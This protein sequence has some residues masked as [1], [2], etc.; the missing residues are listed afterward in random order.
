M[1]S[2]I[3]VEGET[4]DER[5]R[6]QIGEKR[7]AQGGE[8]S[9]GESE[10]VIDEGERWRGRTMARTRSRIEYTNREVGRFAW[11][12]TRPDGAY[13]Y[14]DGTDRT[15]ILRVESVSLEK[16]TNGYCTAGNRP[17]SAVYND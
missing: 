4:R 15:S 2:E 3:K 12:S 13:L 9:D 11:L 17:R 5:P 16:E 1:S 14:E 6:S 7:D 8:T 10:A